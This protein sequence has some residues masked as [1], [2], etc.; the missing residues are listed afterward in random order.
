MIRRFAPGAEWPPGVFIGAA[1][2][3]AAF[4]FERSADMTCPLERRIEKL[5]ARSKIDDRIP[6]YVENKADTDK[7]IDELIA[8]GALDE[9]DRRRCVFWLNYRHYSRWQVR[10]RATLRL[11]EQ[12][13]IRTPCA[14]W[15]A[16]KAAQ[17]RT[18]RSRSVG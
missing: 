10:D 9:S 8:V 15:L 14:T 2:A 16:D 12:A 18:T 17:G 13:R 6:I 7:R 1:P 3:G 11:N 5:E 4:S